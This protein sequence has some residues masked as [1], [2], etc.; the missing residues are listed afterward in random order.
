VKKQILLVIAG[1]GLAVL[2]GAPASAQP[3]PKLFITVNVTFP[4]I[5]GETTLPAGQYTV[6]RDGL[7]VIHIHTMDRT[8]KPMA[9]VMVQ[10]R[11][12]RFSQAERGAI[13]FD[14]IGDKYVLS[15]V[16]LPGEDGYLVSRTSA[17]HTH[18][19]VKSK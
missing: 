4:F 18:E 7:D 2:V 5:V 12:A 17:T 11:L 3:L 13:V 15:E 14:H 8:S 19:V 16:W 10:T 9:I 6:E 1:L